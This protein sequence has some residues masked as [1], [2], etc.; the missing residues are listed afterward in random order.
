MKLSEVA[1]FL[2]A[3]KMGIKS[4][5]ACIRDKYARY[6]GNIDICKRKY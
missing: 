6:I 4:K 5:R 3:S 2:A 1:L